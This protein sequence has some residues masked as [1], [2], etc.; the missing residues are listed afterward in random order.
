MEPPLLFEK[1]P[2]LAGKIE[3]LPLGEYPTPVERMTGL[4][5]SENVRDFFVKRED[6][7]SPF[8]GG[9]KVRKLEFLLARAKALGRRRLIT[10][11]AA[12]SNHIL[13]TVVHG[14]R[15]GMKTIAVMVPQPN[16]AYVRKNLLLDYFHGAQFA[17]AS[18]V[19]TIPLVFA[20]AWMSGSVG[21]NGEFPYVIPPG[22]SNARG[23]L[24]YVN[25]ALELKE[26]VA[27]GLLPEPEFIFVTLGSGGTAAGLIAGTRMA[28]LKSMVIPVR[29]VE[30]VIC[31]RWL[32]SL[33][34][35]RMRSF[36]K[37][38]LGDIDFARLRPAQTTIIDDFAGTRYARFTHAGME[39]VAKARRL[40][41]MKLEGTYTGKTLAG[42][43]N[44]IH[45]H[46]L[47]KR[48]C[49]FLDTYNSVDLY[50]GVR[51]IDFRLLPTALHSYFT[52]PLQEEDMGFE[53]VY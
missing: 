51:D 20:R 41:G 2:G 16:A 9:N 33:H 29:V 21:R 24:G 50:D 12:G 31:N 49:L 27:E 11:G 13:A 39:S 25:C 37:R 30:K 53:V 28:G 35:N 1:Y 34:F 42:A 46:G 3:W 18:T 52:A 48:P 4:A 23:C 10:F 6:L 44:F 5:D 38:N 40:D 17:C 8:Y 22:G 32:L 15:L 43:L 19:A 26:Q 36:L 14:E 47:E 45:K 7:S